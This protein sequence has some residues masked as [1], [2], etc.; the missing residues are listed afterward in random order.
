MEAPSLLNHIASSG[1]ALK[2]RNYRLFFIGQLI[3]QIGSWMQSIGL[4]WLVYRLTHDAFLLGTVA[5]IGDLPMFIL[6]TTAG[7]LADRFNKQKMIIVLQTL[8]MIQAFVLAYLT[9]SG[10]ITVPQIMVLS[11]FSGLIAAFET[12]TRQSFIVEMLDDRDM[13]S[14]ALALNSV[15]FNTSR[16]VGPAI[17]GLVIL[18]VGEGSCFLLNAL[19]FMAVIMALFLIR[20]SYQEKLPIKCFKSDFSEGLRYITHSMPVKHLLILLICVNLVGM[21]YRTLLPIFVKTVL[22][23]EADVFGFLMSAM[24][25]GA[26][27]S[28]TYMASRKSTKNLESLIPKASFLIGIGL[29]TLS[30]TNFYHLALL[31]MVLIGCALVMQ[32]ISSNTLIQSIVPDQMR[33]RIVSFYVMCSM[34][35]MPF[36]NFLAGLM[37]DRIGIQNTLIFDGAVCVLSALLYM[38]RLPRIRL[39]L[40]K[41]TNQGIQL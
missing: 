9:I 36:G 21:S 4:S 1:R 15:L 30:Q 16:L 40:A 26:L 3:S 14:N 41:N 29:L 39:E 13:L 8:F 18:L 31:N 19:S 33:G 25:I 11:L 17:A 37:V 24:G 38:S 5:F 22:H 28:A 35:I 23:M 6:A 32:G 2:N 20:V 34:G 27:F 10:L 12:P 7:V